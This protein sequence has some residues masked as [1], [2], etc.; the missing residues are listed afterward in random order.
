MT[1]RKMGY[2]PIYTGLA[3]DGKPTLENASTAYLSVG[4]E[5]V[6]LDSQEKSIF[7]GA[8]TWYNANRYYLDDRVSITI[9]TTSTNL[10][11]G[12]SITKGGDL[13]RQY[14][15][16][17]ANSTGDQTRTLSILDKNSV[18]VWASTAITDA[19]TVTRLLPTSEQVILDGTYTVTWTLSAVNE[20][21]GMVDYYTFGFDRG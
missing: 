16:T 20:T 10:F 18:T 21:T 3:A 2:V 14:T 13:L 12:T 5:F 7:D 4:A 15:V 6:A 11:S 8:G 17:C 9:N 19:A 1:V